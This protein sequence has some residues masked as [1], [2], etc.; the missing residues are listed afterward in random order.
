GELAEKREQIVYDAG[1]GTTT[2]PVPAD[3]VAAPSLEPAVLAEL[4]R[5]GN[6]MQTAEGIPMDMEFAVAGGRVH[7]LQARP[8]TTLG[9]ECAAGGNKANVWD[10]SNIVESYAGVTT[11]LTFSF[12]RTAYTAVYIQFWET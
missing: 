8:I 12:I 6:I 9:A 7:L 5:L 4:H 11:P 1:G 10:N 3:L 2:I